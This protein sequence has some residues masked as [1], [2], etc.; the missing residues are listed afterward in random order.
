MKPVWKCIR[1]ACALLITATLVHAPFAQADAQMIAV[2]NC[3]G[4][5]RLLVIPGEDGEPGKGGNDCAKA[6]HGSCERRNKLA[7]KKGDPSR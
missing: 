3:N 6:C 2:G 7:G 5:M 1:A 4:T